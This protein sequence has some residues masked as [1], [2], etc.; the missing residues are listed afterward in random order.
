VQARAKS[1]IGIGSGR[2]L[3]VGA[4]IGAAPYL[5]V[6]TIFT[7][8][9]EFW[10]VVACLYR[11]SLNIGVEQS[12]MYIVILQ[13]CIHTHAAIRKLWFFYSSDLARSTMARYLAHITIGPGWND[14]ELCKPTAGIPTLSSAF[15]HK[16]FLGCPRN[17]EWMRCLARGPDG[18]SRMIAGARCHEMVPSWYNRFSR[19]AANVAPCLSKAY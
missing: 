16:P 13:A 14:E 4:T 17:I 12:D 5:T 3:Q 10:T 18:S 8:R 15:I 9:I 19:K 7:E 11:L 2:H 1:R 6:S